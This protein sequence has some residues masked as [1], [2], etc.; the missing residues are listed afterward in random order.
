MFLGT[1]Y[2]SIS[3]PAKIEPAVQKRFTFNFELAVQSEVQINL[4]TGGSACD[5]KFEPCGSSAVHRKIKFSNLS[6]VFNFCP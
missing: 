1:T 6:L 2:Q 4:G 3:D 5:S